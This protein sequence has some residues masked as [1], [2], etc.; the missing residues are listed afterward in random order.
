M[1]ASDHLAPGAPTPDQQPAA[2]GV[3]A[4]LLELRARAEKR[5]HLVTQ[6]T[7]SYTPEEVR[8]LVQELQV[9]Q[10]ELEMQYEELLLAQGETQAARAQ[11]VDLYDFAPVGYFSLSATGQIEQLNFC[12]SKQLGTVRQRLVGRRF[13]LFVA[14]AQRLEFGQFLARV[15]SSESTQSMELQMMRDDGTYFYGQ[16]EGL[17]TDTSA[18]PQCRLAVLD[19]TTR[20]EAVTALAASETRFRKLFNESNDAV[21]L[22]QGHLFV[23]CND[24]A[25]RLLGAR[26]REQ[27]VGKSAWSCAPERQPDG[28]R[29]IDLFRDSITEALRYGSKRCQALMRQASGEEIWLEASLTPIE[30]GGDTPVV[31]IMWRDIT[32]ERDARQEL[33]QGKEFIESL[34][35]NSVDGIIAYDRTLRINT[36][37][38]EAARC[39]G[40]A[41]ANALGRTLFEVLPYLEDKEAHELI[42]RAL[43]GERVDRL[44]Q[45][46]Q[47]RPGNYDVH[48][49]P[50]RPD[51]RAEPNGVLA[52]VRDVTERNRLA[53]EATRQRLR[54]QQAVLS[55]ILTT[56]ES[57]R[58]RIAEALHNGLGQLLY[59][60]K[61]SLERTGQTTRTHGP[62]KLLDEAIRTTRTLSFELTPGV[63]ED[64]GLRTALE[65]LAERLAP[66]NLPVRLHLAGLDGE[67]LSTAVEITVY[68]TVQE[69]LNNV[70]KHAEATEVE[71]HVAR[72]DGHLYVSVEDNGHG[73]DAAT[74]ATQPLTG[75]GLAGVRN[76]V[77]LLGG[78]LS[79]NS[80]LGQGTIV[81]FEL[82]V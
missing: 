68:R 69:L 52:I 50:L 59:A 5:R 79:V 14:P 17:R 18:G 56:Q 80:R 16:L 42:N 75:I 65:T 29:T 1:P 2:S 9:H 54:R 12:A 6:A 33:Q 32:A 43:A 64:F 20:R 72:E 3:H 57:E 62:L 74:L 30:L 21:A 41:A 25:L 53:E 66:A 46:F 34:L 40:V 70:M 4:A 47:D 11:Y 31:H 7:E 38:T 19:A 67:R 37:N 81:S 78:Q 73:F 39:F 45:P 36:W 76:R 51:D 22:L 55:A 63:L 71:V 60:A 61:L 77:A 10:I 13:A 58:K 23:D 44:N 26:H 49:V 35:D 8:R 48:L 27:L 28:R 24:A 15:L 82:D